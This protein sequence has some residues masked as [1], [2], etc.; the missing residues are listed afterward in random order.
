MHFQ[1][2]SRRY[3]GH[4]L[5]QNL[6]DSG[7]ASVQ[8][9]VSYIPSSLT[10]RY[11]PAVIHAWKRCSWGPACPQTTASEWVAA[12]LPELPCPAPTASLIPLPPL[13]Q[14]MA[15]RFAL[16]TSQMELPEG[17]EPVMADRLGQQVPAALPW[18]ADAMT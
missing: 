4:G 16:R 13:S 12:C 3:L 17:I 8:A 9:E 1:T 14:V 10:L 6:A 2:T 5:S 7:L 15:T 11:I 18:P